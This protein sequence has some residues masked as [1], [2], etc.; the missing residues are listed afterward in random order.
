MDIGEQVVRNDNSD[1]DGAQG[2]GFNGTLSFANTWLTDYTHSH[3][4]ALTVNGCDD[5]PGGCLPGDF[6]YPDA[7]Y[8]AQSAGN[9]ALIKDSV[10][11]NNNFASAYT[12]AVARGVFAPA[13]NNVQEPG[14]SPVANVTRLLVENCVNNANC[15]PGTTCQGGICKFPNGDAFPGQFRGGKIMQRVISLDP[16]AANDALA[17]VATAPNDG[18]FTPVLYRGA[19]SGSKNWLCGWTAAYAYGL[20]VAAPCPAD[21]S[22]NGVVDTVDFLALL[23]AWGSAGGDVNCDGTTNTVDFLA[24]LQA[25]G[26]CP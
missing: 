17:S 18:F 16:R 24:L 9:L 4:L 26:P 22:G 15:P 20:T 10:F 5:I 23:Q 14:T 7:L 6:N 8:Q 11:E 2:Y 19:F 13:N 1:G 21:I 25:W 12:E 3:N